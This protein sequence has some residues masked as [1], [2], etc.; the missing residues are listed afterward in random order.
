MLCLEKRIYSV[1]VSGVG[2]SYKLIRYTRLDGILRQT[3][4]EYTLSASLDN[5]LVYRRMNVP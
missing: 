4:K 1:A 5:D 2:L 3:L